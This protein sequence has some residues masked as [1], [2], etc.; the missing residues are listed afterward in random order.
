MRMSDDRI[1]DISAACGFENPSYFT[2]VFM[3]ETGFSPTDFR[4]NRF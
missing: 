3:R 1:T 2:E 4:Q